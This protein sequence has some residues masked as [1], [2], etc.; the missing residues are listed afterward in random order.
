M[1]PEFSTSVLPVMVALDRLVDVI[2]PP[3]IVG[4]EMLIEAEIVPAVIL[5]A[6]RSLIFASV[7][8]RLWICAVPIDAD[9]MLPCVIVAL[10]MFAAPTA[11]FAISAFVMAPV[12]I[13]AVPTASAAIA[14]DVTEL[15]A[16][17]AACT[18]RLASSGFV[19]A[20]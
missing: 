1:P 13:A 8:A 14:V 16:R 18:H 2:E 4:A 3:V 20:R 19:I 5:L 12:W 10:V 17:F 15:A 7:T 11:A 6:L 9:A